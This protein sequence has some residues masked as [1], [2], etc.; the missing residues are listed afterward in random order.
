MI[1]I[2]AV[3]YFMCPNDL[4]IDGPNEARRAPIKAIRVKFGLRRVHERLC[5]TIILSGNTFSEVI[6]LDLT[7]WICKIIS[8]PL[9]IDF[10]L[11]IRHQD[12]TA[13]HPGPVCC[14]HDDF[15]TTVEDIEASPYIW[16]IA[17]FLKRKFSTIGAV[18]H[19]GIVCK[20]PALRKD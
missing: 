18:G 2:I 15:D 16:C 12:R 5:A 3:R 9:P 11:G 4:P 13:D 8:R 14:F 7:A 17:S 19:G 6:C 10:I 1:R 20:S